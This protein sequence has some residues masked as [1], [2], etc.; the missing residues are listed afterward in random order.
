MV[1]KNAEEKDQLQRASIEE[2]M[3]KMAER[4]GLIEVTKSEENQQ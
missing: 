4:Y 3:R 1:K 2:N